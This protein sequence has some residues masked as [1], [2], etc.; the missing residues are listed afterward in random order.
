MLGI[1]RLG[2]VLPL[3]ETPSPIA[4]TSNKGTPTTTQGTSFRIENLRVM[5]PHATKK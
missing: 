1:E 5:P 3:L 4:P 2:R